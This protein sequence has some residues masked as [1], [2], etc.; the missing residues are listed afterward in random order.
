MC[1]IEAQLETAERF[2]DHSTIPIL[3]RMEWLRRHKDGNNLSNQ[4]IKINFA[5]SM[6]SDIANA[7]QL[8]T[9][10]NKTADLF[11][12]DWAIWSEGS[13]TLGEIDAT[14]ISS[15]KEIKS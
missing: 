5:N 15:I 9:F 6:L 13:V 3:K 4:G 12:N 14:R 7:F 10:V 11:Q 1:L 8:S 2:I